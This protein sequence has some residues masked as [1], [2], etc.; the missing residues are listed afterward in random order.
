MLFVCHVYNVSKKNRSNLI[1]TFQRI[2]TILYE[3]TPDMNII[4]VV[5]LTF[6]DLRKIDENGLP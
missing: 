1:K 4:Y 3:S 6:Y 5:L 2:M